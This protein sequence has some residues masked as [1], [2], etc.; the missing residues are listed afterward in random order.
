M[1]FASTDPDDDEQPADA[2]EA[3]AEPI[4][5]P[6]APEAP[7]EDGG[8]ESDEQARE[9]VELAWVPEDD[10]PE[11]PVPE[12]VEANARMI[13][14]A[15][16]EYDLE[17]VERTV[18]GLREE[19]DDLRE[20]NRQLRERIDSLEGWKGRVVGR[21]NS[22]SDDIRKLLTASDL[23]AQGLC[24]ECGDAPLEKQSYLGSSNQIE[25]AGE[26]C[27]HVAAQLE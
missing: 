6:D 19:I 11:K 8:D 26:D 1:S 7:D 15:A 16:D 4:D 22:I 18:E 10:E 25:C 3:D 13:K 20:E 14:G 17:D 27:D 9:T 24:P 21:L 23:D 2:D 5:A 12:A